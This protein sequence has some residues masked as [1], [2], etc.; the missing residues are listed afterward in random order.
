MTS[1]DFRFDGPQ[2]RSADVEHIDPDAGTVLVRAAPY[3]VEAQVGPN[4]WEQFNRGAFSAAAA[5]PHRIK[6]YLNHNPNNPVPIGHA[7]TVEDRRD[8]VWAQFKFSN[9]AAARDAREL[10]ADGTLDQVSVEFRAIEDGSGYTWRTLADGTHVR[11]HRAHLQG[12]ALVP[13]GAYGESAFVAQ[14]R[15][16]DAAAGVPDVRRAEILARLAALNS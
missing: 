6:L 13:H 10:A 16:I 7:K 8:G 12:V 2:W 9:T 4:L 1:D 11:H 15:S 5:A 14:V 3:G